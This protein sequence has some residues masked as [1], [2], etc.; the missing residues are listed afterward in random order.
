MNLLSI[1]YGE[2][3]KSTEFGWF[4][5]TVDGTGETIRIYC[6][7]K[8]FSIKKFCSFSYMEFDNKKSKNKTLVNDILGNVYTPN[9]MFHFEIHQIE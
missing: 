1:F 5:L 4:N 8:I 6:M 9:C 2:K 3:E 7:K